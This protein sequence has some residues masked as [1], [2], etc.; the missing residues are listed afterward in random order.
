MQTEQERTVEA[1]TLTT[2]NQNSWAKRDGKKK[3][4]RMGVVRTNQGRSSEQ[5]RCQRSFA[6][7]DC[8]LVRLLDGE[9]LFESG[10][11]IRS[12]SST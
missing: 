8:A 9:F 7:A 10:K 5:L 1:F 6:G 3:K 12:Q 4:E 2:R 11:C